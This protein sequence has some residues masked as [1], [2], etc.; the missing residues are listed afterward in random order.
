MRRTGIALTKSQTIDQRLRVQHRLF[1]AQ[2]RR[3]RTRPDRHP[4]PHP[5]PHPVVDLATKSRLPP[6]VNLRHLGQYWARAGSRQRRPWPM[7]STDSALTPSSRGGFEPF[8][9]LPPGATPQRTHFDPLEPQVCKGKSM[10]F[11]GPDSPRFNGLACLRCPP[12]AQRRERPTQV[13]TCEEILLP[14]SMNSSPRVG[15]GVAICLIAAF[16]A[17]A[18]WEQAAER[19]GVSPELLYA[20]ARTESGLDPQAIGLNRNGSRDIGLMQINSAWLPKLTRTASRNATCSIPAPASMSAPGSSPA[21]S[22]GWA[23]P[24][25][26]SA[27]TTPRTPH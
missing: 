4:H 23:T 14:K 15:W 19:Y 11:S 25:K 17:H 9:P 8:P 12:Y 5:H 20:I 26:P 3:R 10:H 16:P 2:H 21:T 27:P 22:S 18:C 1:G 13:P 6:I 7:R 24:G